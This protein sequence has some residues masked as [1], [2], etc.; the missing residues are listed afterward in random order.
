MLSRDFTFLIIIAFAIAAPI[1]YYY[2]G[3]WLDKFAYRI[4][5]DATVFVIAGIGALLVATLTVGIKSAQAAVA[6]PADSLKDE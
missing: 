3:Q 2:T 4:D 1:A 5:V 6:S